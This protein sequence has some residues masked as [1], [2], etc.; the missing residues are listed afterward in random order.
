M[1]LFIAISVRQIMV[2]FGTMETSLRGRGAG[3]WNAR[4]TRGWVFLVA[5][6]V[7]GVTYQAHAQPVE[8]DVSRSN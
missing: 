4:T 6:L 7:T 3:S 2:E 1:R 8:E 5:V